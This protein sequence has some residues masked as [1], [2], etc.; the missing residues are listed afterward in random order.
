MQL[1]PT[2]EREIVSYAMN[3][4]ECQVIAE[5]PS[6][7]S[8]ARWKHLVAGG[9][10]GAMSRTCTAPLD[11]LKIVLQVW[12]PSKQIAL[13]QIMKDLLK[14]GGFI[15]L[16]RGNGMNV[17]KVVPEMAFKFTFYE[18]VKQIILATQGKSQLN[19]GDRMIA[20][21]IAGLASQTI[22]YPLEVI[23]TRLVLRK[24]DQSSWSCVQDIFHRGG[25]SPRAF[26][27]GYLPNAI[28]IIPYAG[29]DLAVYETL[30][31]RYIE[32]SGIEGKPS[33]MVLLSCGVCS[34]LLGQTL[35][36][37]LNLIKTRMQATHFGE[38]D[39]TMSLYQNFRY[40]VECYGVFGLYRGLLP[41]LMKV[42]PAVAIIYTVYEHTRNFLDAPMT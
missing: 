11:R 6:E 12:E 3:C 26:F 4:V 9:F 25:K 37:P 20:G 42:A 16:W 1:C 39:S 17:T 14:E 23:K 15:S 27:P 10:A 40:V 33:S 30:K 24:T 28:G 34:S 13:S 22:I 19:M 18:E 35:T 5:K 8:S 32:W 36:Y 41:N 29:I 21:G 31:R 7:V 2:C 38:G